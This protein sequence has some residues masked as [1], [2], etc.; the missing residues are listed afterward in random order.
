MRQILTALR[1]TSAILPSLLVIGLAASAAAGQDV[2]TSQARV[3]TIDTTD[4]APS[5]SSERWLAAGFIAAAAA[6]TPFDRRVAAS[7]QRPGLQRNS[8]LHHT[9]DTFDAAGGI[10]AVALA[11]SSYGIGRLS[12]NDA[13]SRLGFISG[14][15]I[16]ASAAVTNV[17]KI[18]GG[19]QR[20][21]H[22]GTGD[23]DD[24]T[25]G[26]GYSEGYASFPS[27]H[28][29]AAFA[30]ATVLTVESSHWSASS[31]RWVGP[32]AFGSAA[33]VGASRMYSNA[34]WMSDVIAGAGVGTVTALEVERLNALHP[35]NRLERIFLGAASHLAPDGNGATRIAW[36]VAAP[37]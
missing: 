18:G 7:L 26:H 5:A 35:A 25:F 20:P 9:A 23:S 37:R 32:V 14:E 17:I 6:A 12:G 33:L 28:A 3:A 2:P 4:A 11:V 1:A 8:V 29:T 24:F 13:L 31:A 36:T 21:S 15:A 27:G 10:G 30:T 16:V 19:R 34:H 22:A